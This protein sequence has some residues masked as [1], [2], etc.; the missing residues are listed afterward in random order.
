M[1]PQYSSERPGWSGGWFPFGSL[2]ATQKGYHQKV[3]ILGQPRAFPQHVLFR[4]L[5]P[6]LPLEAVL[7]LLSAFGFSTLSRGGPT[8]GEVQEKLKNV[9]LQRPSLSFPFNRTFFGLVGEAHE[10]HGFCLS[11]GCRK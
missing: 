11:L 3:T 8:A 2:K 10:V 5:P 4:Q 9:L 7:V 1:S 6:K